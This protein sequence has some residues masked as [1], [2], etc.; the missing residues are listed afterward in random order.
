MHRLKSLF[1]VVIPALG[2]I[3]WLGVGVLRAQDDESPEQKQYREDYEK[4]Q[5]LVAIPD[6]NKRAEMLLG[7]IKERP[8]SKLMDYAQQSY[9]Q[10]L[11]S[12]SKGE[13]FP[14]VIALSEKLIAARPRVGEAYYY[15][16]AALKNTGK[17]NEAMNALAKAYVIK[18]PASRKAKEFLDFLYK[19]KNGSLIGQ[20]KLI[21]SAE[22]EIGK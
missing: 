19:Q 13:K 2:L 11:D 8:N 6:L 20:E 9:L 14:A 1:R 7:F 5:K 12:L 15:Y 16:G 4:T 17:M 10:V 18:T 21:K 22:A 3:L